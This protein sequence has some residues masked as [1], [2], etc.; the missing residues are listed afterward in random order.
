MPPPSS[1]SWVAPTPSACRANF[2][3]HD[4]QDIPQ[5]RATTCTSP[6]YTKALRAIPARPDPKL[7]L[8][9]RTSHWQLNSKKATPK[10]TGL[11]LIGEIKEYGEHFHSMS[12]IHFHS[13]LDPPV[14]LDEG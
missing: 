9:L 7:L 14:E 13:D 2:K 6:F 8:C 5:G 11:S 1:A 12:T 4:S 10:P 3:M